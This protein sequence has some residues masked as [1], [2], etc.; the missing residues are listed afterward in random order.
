MQYHKDKFIAPILHEEMCG[1]TYKTSSGYTR[2]DHSVN[3]HDDQIFSYLMAMYVWYDCPELSDRFGIIRGEIRT[4]T[5]LEERV[6]ALEDL[7]GDGYEIVDIEKDHVDEDDPIFGETA[8]VI[9]KMIQEKTVNT[10]QMLD[11]QMEDDHKALLQVMSTPYGRVAVEKAY[12]ID[13]S[14]PS[15][16]GYNDV[17]NRMGA[18]QPAIESFYQDDEDSNSVDNGNLFDQFMM[19]N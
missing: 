13:L 8:S 16:Y 17:L 19:I 18:A 2:V 12:H 6:G 3:T 4:D 14:Q 10:S 9:N 5:D 15:I 7:Y 11:K 1:L